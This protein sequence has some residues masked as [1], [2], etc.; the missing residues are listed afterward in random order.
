MQTLFSPDSK[1]MQAL[2]R[3]ADLML[4]NLLFLL[5]CIPVVTIG[6]SAAALY[7]V[8]LAMGT[9][10]EDG[11]IRPYFRA[12]RENFLSALKAWLILLGVAAA[13]ILDLLLAIRLGGVFIWFS[14]VFA[15]LLAMELLAA[16]MLFPLL[17][18]FQNSTLGTLKNAL[19]L[20]LGQLPRAAAIAALWV[21]PLVVLWYMPLTFFYA[22]FIWI[23][24]Y[25][26]GAAFLAS[27]LLK[28]VF[29][30]YLPNEEDLT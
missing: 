15:I 10:R 7:R 4:L 18:L 23:V 1:F 26:S 6:P 22:A 3:G 12:F 29:A 24:I 14:L 21:F 28:P 16:A 30:P 13:L 27:L 19:V 2:S 25:F 20:G 8:I 17:S 9:A 11:I 5:T